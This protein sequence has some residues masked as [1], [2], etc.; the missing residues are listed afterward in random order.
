LAVEI[1][2]LFSGNLNCHECDDKL[3]EER[4]CGQKGLRAFWVGGERVF[5]CP[6]SLVHEESWAL[7]KAYNFFEKGMLPNEGGW[8]NQPNDYIQAMMIL[9]NEFN[10]WRNKEVQK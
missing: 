8:I 9:D 2:H 3:K 6:M 5:Q 7:I 1:L 10:K 4:G